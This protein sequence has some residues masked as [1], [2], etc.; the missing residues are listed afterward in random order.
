M[1]LRRSSRDDRGV[2]V[3]V[4]TVLLVGM[5]TMGMAVLGAAVLSTDLVDSPPRADLVYQEQPSGEVIIGIEDAR[6]LSGDGT[7]VQLQDGSECREWPSSGAIESGDTITIDQTDC[8]FQVGDRL[9]VVGSQTLLD[10]YRLRGTSPPWWD[11]SCAA[12]GP[13]TSTGMAN[14]NDVTIDTGDTVEC[15]FTSS[16][17]DRNFDIN[18]DS[19]LVGDVN[20]SAGDID[21]DDAD[22]YGYVIAGGNDITMTDEARITRFVYSDGNVD[23]DGDSTVD[24][25]VLATGSINV[26]D[27]TIDGKIY[28]TGDSDDVSI[29]GGATHDGLEKV[30]SK[31]ELEDKV[32]ELR[33]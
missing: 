6:S 10:T 15:D 3:V 19:A 2:S 23:I 18:N 29:S 11:Y 21:V 12:D 9:Q 33:S 7:Y 16:S 17:E 27:S 14:S 5:V 13:L 8:N 32:E 28:Y 24:G 30:A 25:P 4:G 22:V 20:T 1:N 31:S 26:D